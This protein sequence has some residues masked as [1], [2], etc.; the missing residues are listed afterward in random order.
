MN[1]NNHDLELLIFCAV[2]LFISIAYDLWHL[3]R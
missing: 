1:E 2:L 3:L